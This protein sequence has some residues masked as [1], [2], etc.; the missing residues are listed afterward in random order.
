VKRVVKDKVKKEKEVFKMA[1][2]KR[3]S[4]VV[5]LAQKRLAGLQSISSTLDLGHGLTVANYSAALANTGKQ[6]DTYNTLLSSADS[7]QIDLEKNEKLLRDLSERMLEAVGSVYGHDSNEYEQAG[8]KRKSDRKRPLH[9][10][11][12]KAS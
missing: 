5:E 1:L 12:P 2:K 6:L 3:K 7:A 4:K 8:G 10:P 9:K 11:K